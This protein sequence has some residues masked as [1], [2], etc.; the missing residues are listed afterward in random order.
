MHIN[1]KRLRRKALKYDYDIIVTQ[2]ENTG[3]KNYSLH[4][5]LTDEE[6]DSYADAIQLRN[7]IDEISFSD[8]EYQYTLEDGSIVGSNIPLF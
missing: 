6:V 4:D 7:A 1:I 2:N 3:E 5:M 8:I